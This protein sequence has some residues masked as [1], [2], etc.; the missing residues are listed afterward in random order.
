MLTLGVVAVSTPS[1]GLTL[2]RTMSR[3]VVAT[4][5]SPLSRVSVTIRCTP[6]HPIPLYIWIHTYA[7]RHDSCAARGGCAAEH[8]WPPPPREPHDGRANPVCGQGIDCI[9]SRVS[10]GGDL[11]RRPA[12]N[13]LLRCPVRPGGGADDEAVGHLGDNPRAF[14]AAVVVNGCLVASRDRFGD[15]RPQAVEAFSDLVL[16]HRMPTRAHPVGDALHREF[17]GYE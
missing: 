4:V 14:D 1:A 9:G 16:R 12:G 2:H 13:Q 15:Q 6:V 3:S 11:G 7:I 8:H 17:L 5:N 10:A